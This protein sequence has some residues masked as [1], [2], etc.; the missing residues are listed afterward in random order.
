[1]NA[2]YDRLDARPGITQSFIRAGVIKEGEGLRPT[3]PAAAAVAAAS[4]AVLALAGSGVAA[5]L[6]PR[7]EQALAEAG[8]YFIPGGDHLGAFGGQQLVMV[9]AWLVSWA[10]L[11]AR[12]RR[13]QVSL[14]ATTVVL[15][16]CL[17][18][19]TLLLWP[20]VLRS[21]PAAWG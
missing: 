12:W 5:A 16:V 18:A 15:V 10:L 11:H 20:P 2:D 3:G 7:F 4:V 8:R 19:G 14:T 9:A 6:A 17:A 13:R 1:M 21:L